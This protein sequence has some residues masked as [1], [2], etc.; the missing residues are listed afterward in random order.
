MK[1]FYTAETHRC[2]Q[3]RSRVLRGLTAGLGLGALAGCIVM[4]TQV[5]TATARTM[6]MAVI[7]LSTLGG[8]GV[9]LTLAYGYYPAR[10]EEAHIAGM[11]EE[12]ET[13]TVEGVLTLAPMQVKIPGSIAFARGSIRPDGAEEAMP[14]HV[15]ARLLRQMPPAGS[16]VRVTVARRFITALEVLHE[17]A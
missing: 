5:N 6:L 9:L 4:C 3:R 7:T 2:W 13:E 17:E 1:W 15:A 8:W 12:T 14:V 11:L 16:R 10:A